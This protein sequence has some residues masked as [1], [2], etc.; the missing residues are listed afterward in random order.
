METLLKNIENISDDTMLGL[1]PD[2]TAILVKYRDVVTFM[3]D[4]FDTLENNPRKDTHFDN[5]K[6]KHLLKQSEE[7]SDP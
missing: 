6:L 2:F 5:D 4:F 3:T 1:L 7:Q